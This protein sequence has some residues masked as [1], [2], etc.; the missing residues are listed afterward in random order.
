[1]PRS[2]APLL[3]AELAALFGDA[4]GR[5]A[6]GARARARAA[7]FTWEETARRTRRVYEEVLA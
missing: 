2:E 3:A 5:A 6:L 7:R 1:V 4:E